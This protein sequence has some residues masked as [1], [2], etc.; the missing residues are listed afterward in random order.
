M[1]PFFEHVGAI[2][3]PRKTT[4]TTGVRWHHA[5]PMHPKV[6][7]HQDRTCLPETHA[8]R[9]GRRMKDEDGRR[10]RRKPSVSQSEVIHIRN[11][12]SCKM[13]R[14]E[15]LGGVVDIDS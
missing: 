8:T 1:S 15:K 2:R 13:K 6:L 11:R 7:H 9:M 12:K 3:S 10:R 4:L 14:L 5:K